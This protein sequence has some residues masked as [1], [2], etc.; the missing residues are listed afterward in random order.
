[1]RRLV[2]VLL[3]LF[4]VLLKKKWTF[5]SISFARVLFS[6]WDGTSLVVSRLGSSCLVFLVSEVYEA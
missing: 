2:R 4:R 1:V 5:F 6:D 3:I